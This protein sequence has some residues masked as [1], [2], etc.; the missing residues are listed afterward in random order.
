MKLR[1][2]TLLVLILF[3]VSCVKEVQ[4][5]IKPQSQ[6]AIF[7]V[8]HNLTD[9]IEFYISKTLAIYED[10]ESEEIQDKFDFTVRIYEYPSSAGADPTSGTLFL[11]AINPKILSDNFGIGRFITHIPLT[12]KA[13]IGNGYALEVTI[14]DKVIRSAVEYLPEPIPVKDSSV[15]SEELTFDLSFD[16]PPDVMN[17]YSFY[18]KY[19]IKPISEEVLIPIISEI[20]FIGYN[21]RNDVLFSGNTNTNFFSEL[22]QLEFYYETPF[23]VHVESRLLTLEHEEYEFLRKLELS[24]DQSYENVDEGSDPFPL[25]S[26]PPVKLNG[27]LTLRKGGGNKNIF[28]FFIVAGADPNGTNILEIDN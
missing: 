6:Y 10:F 23:E 5:D 11:E 19:Y 14:D 7:T 15:S 13:V 17:Y 16:D 27:N 2:L 28:G 12:R 26:T 3:S 9:H 25:F 1:S 18:E 8:L 20:Q 21:T 22:K 24:S 4:Y